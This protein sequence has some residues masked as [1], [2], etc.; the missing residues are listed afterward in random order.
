MPESD[1]TLMSALLAVQQAAPK[2]QKDAINPHFKNKY[3]SL[4]KLMDAVLPVL[5]EH[6]L[7]WVTLPDAD[8]EGRPVLR[9]RLIHTPTVETL[10]GSMP[11]LLTKQDPQGQ[12]SAITYARRY[13]LMAV[14]GLVANTDDDARAASRSNRRQQ[15]DD[16]SARLLTGPERQKVLDAIM[17]NHD[18]AG[19]AKLLG[20]V[21]A[22]SMDEVTTA[23]AF[24]L[25]KLLDQQAAR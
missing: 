10:E 24:E 3:V 23:Q 1:E 11:L 25:R 16:S 9:Y 2:L 15:S 22:S 19:L 17:A 5:N 4:D 12:G 20:A 7:A 6:K 21:G 8:S 14:L 18:E 13:S